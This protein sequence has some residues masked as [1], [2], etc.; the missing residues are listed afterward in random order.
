VLGQSFKLK[1]FQTSRKKKELEQSYFL[2]TFFLSFL[3]KLDNKE[4]ITFYQFFPQLWNQ[5]SPLYYIKIT[6]VTYVSRRR[7]NTGSLNISQKRVIGK[8]SYTSF[9]GRNLLPPTNP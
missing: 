7:A 5:I 8:Y 4:N 1:I 3:P 2:K 6:A 9:Y